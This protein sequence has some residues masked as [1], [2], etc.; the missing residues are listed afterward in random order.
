M[1]PSSFV[2]GAQNYAGCL[3]GFECFFANPTQSVPHAIDH[4]GFSA[5]NAAP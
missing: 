5:G 2:G 4:G 1:V 3:A